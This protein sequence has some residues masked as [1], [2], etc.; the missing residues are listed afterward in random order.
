MAARHGGG[1]GEDPDK[2]STRPYLLR[3]IYEWALDH[4]LTPQVLVDAGVDGVMLPDSVGGGGRIALTI[5]PR[6]VKGLEMNNECLRF[7]AR[8]AGRP[9]D[10]LVPV[11]AVLAIYGREN[12]RGIFF[13]ND[14]DEPPPA[15]APAPDTASAPA[16]TNGARKKNGAPPRPPRLR[17]VK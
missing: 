2:A 17:L 8:F 11:A 7:S 4:G 16:A 10:V 12:G 9:H 3:A 1:G 5:H 6:A 15:D 14:M 13:H